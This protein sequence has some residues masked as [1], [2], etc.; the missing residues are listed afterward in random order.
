[1]LRIISLASEGWRLSLM[2]RIFSFFSIRCR[3][4][5]SIYLFRTFDL[6]TNKITCEECVSH[7]WRQS[8]SLVGTIVAKRNQVSESTFRCPE[9]FPDFTTPKPVGYTWLRRRDY[10]V[11]DRLCF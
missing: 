11:N 1:M 5:L 9:V 6:L 8:L 4:S 2:S 3:F 7:W 10:S